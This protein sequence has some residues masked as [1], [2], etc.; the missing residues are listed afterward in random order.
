MNQEC[1]RRTPKGATLGDE[2]AFRL[3]A[4]DLLAGDDEAA[5]ELLGRYS[6]Q[7]VTL[8]RQQMSARLQTKVAPEDVLQSVF[9]TFFR[10]L[11]A[12]EFELRGWSALW[13]FLSLLTLRKVQHNVDRYTTIGRDLT[14]EIS[15]DVLGGDSWEIVIPDRE[16]T[17]DEAAAFAETLTNLFAELDDRDRQTIEL[18]FAGQKPVEIAR[19]LGC[20][21]RTVRRTLARVR[22]KLIRQEARNERE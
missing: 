21:Q 9:R 8:A 7:L 1:V 13:G 17:P 11:E 16:P 4:D 19:R 18:V 15:L 5:R 12:G 22:E 10:R 6:A 14:R 3:F 20:S 2:T